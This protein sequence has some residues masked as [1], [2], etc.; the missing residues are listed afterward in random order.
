MSPSLLILVLPLIG[1]V[2]VCARRRNEGGLKPSALLLY[3]AVS[4][5][6][7]APLML[8]LYYFSRPQ[9]GTWIGRIAF[10]F[11]MGPLLLFSFVG[12]GAIGHGVDR[13]GTFIWKALRRRR[14]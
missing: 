11:A 9:A 8:G 12:I 13:A 4:S 2:F 10:S 3:V 6:S 14:R 7:V 5:I 1:L